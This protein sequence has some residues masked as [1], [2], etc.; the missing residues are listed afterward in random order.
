VNSNKGPPHCTF[1]GVHIP[2]QGLAWGELAGLS[3]KRVGPTEGSALTCFQRSQPYGGTT[4]PGHNRGLGLAQTLPQPV[5]SNTAGKV[6]Y[7]CLPCAGGNDALPNQR[8]SQLHRA[9]H[10]SDGGANSV[11]GVLVPGVFPLGASGRLPPGRF[12]GT[13]E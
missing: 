9:G 10:G 3:G 8:I 2:T 7:L 13:T 1:L 4:R 11:V 5:I 12:G 6:N